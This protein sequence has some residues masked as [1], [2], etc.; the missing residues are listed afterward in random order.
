MSRAPFSPPFRAAVFDLDG[1]L[2]DGYRGVRDGLN[3]VLSRYGLP[4]ISVEGTKRM[5]GE[6]LPALMESF[7]G[8]ERAAEAVRLFCEVYP[9]VAIAGTVSMPG[10]E[11][12]L[13]DLA[14]AGIPAAIASNKPVE[15]CRLLVESLGLA[16]FLVAVAAPGEGLPPKP[17]PAMVN[18]LLPLLGGDPSRV[19]FVGDMPVDVATARAAGMPVAALPTGSSTREEL[20][21]AGPDRIVDS[22]DGLRPFFG[23]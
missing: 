2:I 20:E 17:D 8:P 22:L 18:V 7:V 14:R 21:A 5:V 12:L 9:A 6:G 15:F 19:L 10:A 3:P 4:R 11:S 13:A 16:G 23:I 1:T